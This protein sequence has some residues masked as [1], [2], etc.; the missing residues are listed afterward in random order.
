MAKRKIKPVLDVSG[1]V[2]FEVFGNKFVI[3]KTY[4]LHTIRQDI[5]LC[6][7]GRNPG[8]KGTELQKM[9]GDP[10]TSTMYSNLKSLKQH[11]LVRKFRFPD[12]KGAPST[13]YVLTPRGDTVVK[14]LL[15][16][17]MAF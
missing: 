13:Y 7:N 5:L 17:R 16:Y 11:G 10:K 1:P 6:L 4:G 15:K 14:K 2:K 12:K 8:L 3:D 9:I